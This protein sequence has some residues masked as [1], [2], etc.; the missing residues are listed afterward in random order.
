M[1]AELKKSRLYVGRFYTAKEFVQSDRRTDGQAVLLYVTQL[2]L[3]WKKSSLSQ[4]I[5]VYC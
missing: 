1:T 2:A 4:A 3:H 5:S